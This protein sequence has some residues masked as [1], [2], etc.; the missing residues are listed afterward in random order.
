MGRRLFQLPGVRQWWARSYQAVTAEEIPW[1]PLRRPLPECRLALVTT[2]G[3]HLRTDKPFDM[4]DPEG[5]PSFRRIPAQAPPEALQITHGYYDHTDADQDRNLVL[6][7]DVLQDLVEAG[8]LK[9]TTPEFFSFM[10]HIEGPH[11]TTLIQKTALEAAREIKRQQA[12]V[13]LLV[14]A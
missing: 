5:D 4:T 2:G 8:E 9:D 12:D 3:V 10:G 11:L 1:T 14:P 13:A 7:M 6:P